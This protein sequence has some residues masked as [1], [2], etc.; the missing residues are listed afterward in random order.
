MRAIRDTIAEA[1]ASLN[2]LER[3]IRPP[4]HPWYYDSAW[5]GGKV[6]NQ[7][8]S[9]ACVTNVIRGQSSSFVP[10]LGPWAV[11]WT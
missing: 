1:K 3:D 2:L 10:L 6:G 5:G 7:L 9:L 4:M 8:R 11:N